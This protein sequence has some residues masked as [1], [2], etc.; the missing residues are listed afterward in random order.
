M[1][2]EFKGWYDKRLRELASEQNTTPTQL[3]IEFIKSQSFIAQDAEDTQD[4]NT[5][6]NA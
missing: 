1:R 2:L 4:D 6:E 3:V 5:K